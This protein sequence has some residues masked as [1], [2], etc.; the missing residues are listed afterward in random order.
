MH[1]HKNS[2]CLI[3]SLLGICLFSTGCADIELHPD[4]VEYRIDDNGTELLFQIGREYPFAYGE[5]AF[6]VDH[7]K[8]RKIKFKIEF[9]NGKKDGNFT[10]WQ[11]NGLRKLTGGFNQGKRNGLFTAYG[12]IGELVYQKKIY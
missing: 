5:R 10:F 9:Q 4:D 1:T 11:E 8:N 2:L 12:K 6:I 7:Y 3:L